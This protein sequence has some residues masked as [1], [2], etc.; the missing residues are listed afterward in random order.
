MWLVMEIPGIGRLRHPLHPDTLVSN[1]TRR[2]YHAGKID[3][4]FV[5][6]PPYAEI[7]LNDVVWKLKGPNILLI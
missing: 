1:V 7:P 4:P 2:A 6:I 5:H 3:F